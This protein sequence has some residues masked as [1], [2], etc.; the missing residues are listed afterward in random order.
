MSIGKYT[1]KRLLQLIPIL[2]GLTLVVYG[3]MYISPG[4]PATKKLL[5]QGIEVNAE[6]LENVREEMGLNRPF[7]VQYGDW[8]LGLFRGDLGISYR[9]GLPVAQ[10]LIS[11]LKNTTL[12]ALSSLAFSVLISIPLGVYIAVRQNRAGDYII[13]F[14]S[15]VGNSMPNFL[16]SVL[17]MYFLCIRVKLFPVIAKQSFTGLLLPA[18]AIS[19]PMTSRFVR[20]VRAQVLE[21]LGKPYVAGARA[22]GVK[23]RFVLFSNVLRNASSPIVTIIGLSVGGLFGGSV[24]VESIFSW[25]GLGKLAMDA[26]TARDYPV[27]QGFVLIT[28]VIYV[29]VN[30]LTDLSYHRLDPRVGRM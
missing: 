6:V 7:L 19:I 9:D 12:L 28:G 1:A 17:L 24:V 25:P 5:S 13:R 18:L 26:I 11:G 14:L 4:D 2:I 30:L 3:L 20:Q 23:E 22:R 29:I 15:F 27:I 16:I 21:E 10:K 8:F